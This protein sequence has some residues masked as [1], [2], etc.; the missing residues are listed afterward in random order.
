[1]LHRIIMLLTVQSQSMI[2]SQ[3]HKIW[4]ATAKF[5]STISY[6]LT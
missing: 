2:D 4:W 6:C 5:R 3:V 1:V